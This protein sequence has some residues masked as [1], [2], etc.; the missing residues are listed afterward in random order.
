MVK[1]LLALHEE[2]RIEAR[3]ALEISATA[4]DI[5][6]ADIIVFC[7]N[8]E[9]AYGFW[10]DMVRAANK[11]YIYDLDDNLFKLPHDSILGEYHGSPEVLQ[12]L[13]RYVQGAALV[14]VYSDG[15][16]NQIRQLNARV[17]IV[18][19]SVDLKLVDG[20]TPRSK[21]SGVRLAYVTSRIEDELYHIFLPAV[22]KLLDQMPSLVEVHFWGTLPDQVVDDPRVRFIPY[23]PDYDT[24]L[25]SFR[26]AAY[27]IG[28][29]PLKND[30]FHTAKSNNKFREYGACGV[31]GV[32][33]DVAVYSVDVIDGVSG[34][35]VPNETYAWYEALSRLVRSEGLR[36]RITENARAR[37]E[38]RYSLSRSMNEW[39]ANL[40]A[41]RRKS[42]SR[43][44]SSLSALDTIKH[45][46]I[47]QSVRE[48]DGMKDA[49]QALKILRSI[50]GGV[51]SRGIKAALVQVRLRLY[52][53]RTLIVLRLKTSRLARLVP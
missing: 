47:Q 33:S 17:E 22:Q 14:R 9:P 21:Y 24:Y 8:S 35:L 27:D 30:E 41:V 10:L 13:T 23:N 37:V 45:Q 34:L 18:S 39:T 48:A 11:P 36:N 40:D 3:F 46:V 25:R 32:Y 38:N 7:R 12:Q 1:P 31:A 49:R 26:R 53:W 5:E 4:R 16:F 28:L 50:I 29:A 19:G 52:Q 15:L 2:G 20:V 43:P 51:R 42:G 44:R 6:R